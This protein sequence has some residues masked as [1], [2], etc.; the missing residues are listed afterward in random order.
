MR[1]TPVS[2]VLHDVDGTTDLCG[3]L[4]EATPDKAHC[5]FNL[6]TNAFDTL[7]STVL[8]LQGLARLRSF[9]PKC[10]VEKSYHTVPLKIQIFH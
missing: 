5:S 10:A 9:Q 6:L 1:C 2:A 3:V 7:A 4:V 8:V